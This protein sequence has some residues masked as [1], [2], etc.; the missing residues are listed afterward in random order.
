MRNTISSKEKLYTFGAI[1]GIP[2]LVQ[3]IS[4]SHDPLRST[5]VFATFVIIVTLVGI[6]LIFVDQ[7]K[8]N[9]EAAQSVDQTPADG[10]VKQPSGQE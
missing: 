2:T 5:I 4:L 3:S 1:V 10:E 9:E 6:A 8:E 7:M